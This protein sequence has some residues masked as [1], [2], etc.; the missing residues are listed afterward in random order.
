MG[1]VAVG[2]RP[3]LMDRYGNHPDYRGYPRIASLAEL[4]TLL[5]RL[6]RDG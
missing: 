2:I 6:N 1:A 4:Q 3:I 5:S